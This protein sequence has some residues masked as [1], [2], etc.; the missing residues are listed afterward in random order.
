[1][2][3]NS[4]ALA[5]ADF[6]MLATPA[7]LVIETMVRV[8]FAETDAMGVVYH[9]NYLIWFEVGRSAYWRAL[10]LAST[11]GLHDAGS[12][13]VSSIE[14]HYHSPARYGDLV[15]IRTRVAELRSRSITFGYEC[16]LAES[17]VRLATGQ[18]THLFLDETG[19]ARR[20]PEPLRQALT[21]KASASD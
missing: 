19:H 11:P 6:R 2:T 13:P 1:M 10:Q 15:I 4:R 3:E 9:T 21:G 18:T 8:R 5:P 17:G 14:G 20:L 7:G 12:F 16:L